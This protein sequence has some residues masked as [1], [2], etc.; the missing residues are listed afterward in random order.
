MTET[1]R[2]AAGMVGGCALGVVVV[3]LTA[4][5]TGWHGNGWNGA[6]QFV[7]GLCALGGMAVVAIREER[8]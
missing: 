2:Y 5:L 7:F 3:Y 8:R 4:R 1:A 6:A